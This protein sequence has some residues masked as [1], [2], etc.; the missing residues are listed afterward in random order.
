M[1]GNVETISESLKVRD[2][3]VVESMMSREARMSSMKLHLTLASAILRR[4]G[5]IFE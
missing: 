5:A 4:R 2:S 1:V 3:R